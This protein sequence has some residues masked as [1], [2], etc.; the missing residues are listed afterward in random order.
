V[1]DES[2]YNNHG[3]FGA[4]TIWAPGLTDIE[5]WKTIKLFLG[6]YIKASDPDTNFNSDYKY[7]INTNDIA[8]IKTPL[9]Q[10]DGYIN[11]ASLKLKVNNETAGTIKVARIL[12]PWDPATVTFNSCPNIDTPREIAYT[13][14]NNIVTLDVSEEARAMYFSNSYGLAIWGPTLTILGN[15]TESQFVPDL[16]PTEMLMPQ[17][18]YAKRVVTVRWRPILSRDLIRKIY[19]ER[20]GIKVF[21]TNDKNVTSFTDTG[22]DPSTSYT[23]SLKIERR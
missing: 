15:T 7:F 11:G 6:T 18:I 23:Y 5:P 8:L 2:G 9:S 10:S 1:K 4:G 20:N 12:S 14:S 13:V 17:K 3:T 22:L 21:E 19:V 16:K